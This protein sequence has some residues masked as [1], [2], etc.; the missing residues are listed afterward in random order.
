MSTACRSVLRQVERE[1]KGGS[2]CVCASECARVC[3][4]EGKGCSFLNG[5]PRKVLLRRGRWT[6]DQ[7]EEG[8]GGAA[9]GRGRGRGRRELRNQSGSEGLTGEAG[10]SPL[11]MRTTLSPQRCVRPR[12][13]WVI[14]FPVSAALAPRSC[15]CVGLRQVPELGWRCC[16]LVAESWGR[17]RGG[18]PRLTGAGRRG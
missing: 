3:A 6:P 2:E 11:R 9:S 13:W 15:C 18:E 4:C 7:R 17:G 1:G 16:E 12:P 8:A 14:S 10:L 5:W